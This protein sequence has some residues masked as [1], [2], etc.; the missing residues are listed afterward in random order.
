MISR[1]LPLILSSLAIALSTTLAVSSTATAQDCIMPPTPEPIRVL[2]PDGLPILLRFR[3]TG[4]NHWYEDLDG[5]PVVQVGDGYFFARQDDEGRLLPTNAMVGRGNPTLLG[6]PTG[7]TPPPPPPSSSASGASAALGSKSPTSRG[8]VL[9]FL[10]GTGTVKNLVIL[11]RFSNHGPGGQNRSLPSI[12]DVDKIMNEPGG[13][14]SLA[15]TGSVRDHYLED[16]YGQ[17]TINSTVSVWVD[18]P[19]S[20]SYYANNNSG[21]T[22]RTWDLIT[23]GLN[24]VDAS[25]DFSQFDNDGDGV[26][27]AITFLHSGYGAEWGGTD[28]YGT[29]YTDRM[30]S[31]KWSI[32]TWTS[33][34]GVTVSEYNISPGLWGTSGSGPGRIGVVAH[35]L[36]HFFGLP[37]LYDTD[38]SSNGN[39]NWCLMAAG[40]WGFDGSQQYPSHMGA[41][42]KAKMGWLLPQAILPGNHSVPRVEDTPSVYKVDN[43]YPPGEYLL[44]ENRAAWGFDAQLPT[45][46]LA[47]WH[48]DET[49]GSFGSNNPN[50]DEGYSGQS[51]WPGNGKHYRIALLQADNDYDLERDNNRGDSG[52]LYRGGGVSSITSSS[53]PSSDSYQQ[54]SIIDNGN[55]ITGIGNAG[56][57]IAMTFSNSFSPSITTTSLPNGAQNTAYSHTLTAS[58]GDAPLIWTEHLENPTYGM[59]DLGNNLYSS[60]GTAQGW[61]AD[62][63]IWQLTLP[64]EFPYYDGSY[65]TCYVSSNGFIEFAPTEAEPRNS[66]Y[67]LRASR[68]IAPLWDDLITNGGGSQDIYV[69]TSNNGQVKIRWHGETYSGGNTV[70][71]S[72]VLFNDGRVRFDYGNGNSGISPNVGISRGEGGIYDFPSSHDGAS[73]LSNANS[74]MFTLNGSQMPPGLSLSTGGVLSGTPTADAT[75]TPWFRVTDNKYRYDLAQL[76]IDVGSTTDCNSNGVDDSDDIANGTSQDC[77]INGIPDE[78]EL[79]GND[80]DSNGVPDPCELDC[81]SNSIPD[82]CESGPDCNSN[83]IPDDCDLTGNDCNTNSVPDECELPGNDCNSNGTPDECDLASND[84]NT[85]SIPDECELPGNDCNSNGTPDDC[86]LTGN[87]CNSNGAPDECELVGNDCN[88]NG[89]PDDCELA[90]DCNG[91]TTPDDCELV[92]NDCNSNGFPDECDIIFDCNTNGVPDECEADCNTNGTPD[93]CESGPDCNLNGTPDD[94]ELTGNDCNFNSVPDECDLPANDCNLNGTPDDCELIGN[95][96][97]TNGTPDDCELAGNDCNSNGTPDDCELVGDCNGNSTP[98][99]CELVGNDCN[100]NGFPDECDTLIDCNSNGVPDDCDDDCNSNGIP[101]DCESGPDCNSNGTPDD[102]EL[103]SNDCDLNGVP[104]ECDPDC[105]SN[106]TP[107]ACDSFADCNS[108]SVPDECELPGNDCNTNGIPDECDILFDCNSNGVPDECETDC[109][110]NGNPDD[111][112]SFSDCN[113]NGTPDECDIS[114]GSSQDSDLNGIPDECGP[115]TSYCSGDGSGTP[116]PCANTGAP[117][118]GCANSSS[119]GSTLTASGSSSIL[120]DDLVFHAA[121]LLPGQAALLFS[122][123]NQI[124]GGNG[125]QFGDGLRCVGGQITRLNVRIPDASGDASWGPGMAAV[126]G[127][128]SGE[129]RTFQVWYR[130]SIGSSCGTGFNLSNG[131]SVPLTN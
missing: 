59:S 10:S 6:I 36:G 118:A 43:G 57:N 39:G 4:Y 30:W 80:C 112:E 22:S 37:D 111:C 2:Q 99:E 126:H 103:A 108:N 47:I 16:S 7:V 125:L 61:N 20:E 14:P 113:N 13:H 75:Y 42:A 29:S 91:N 33:A 130:D 50:T 129:T 95:D 17:L 110:N 18:V 76:N 55:A 79:A 87:D 40:S 102:C 28:S 96:C 74:V 41:W 119:V 78:C 86:D 106:N 35:E 93:D 15:P 8:G 71:F 122:G 69:D 24:I 12:A 56:A 68:R 60:S 127:W 81:N 105:N 1:Q 9:P 3:G 83:G 58:G 77:N 73:N 38:G 63:S 67:T 27:D 94:C 52:D 32:P 51:G 65:G 85:N 48:V 44:V 66:P 49:K 131:L 109:N 88:N 104:D 97:N 107:D 84:C 54:G 124:N 89:T 128:I 117:G 120:A 46:G 45:E 82:A 92:G 62:D 25:I 11:L 100:S 64:F 19:D 31:H 53:S 123:F 21:L 23:D 5:H 98:D 116:C 90:G 101:D 26:I 72:V 34:E 70:R 121:G 114:S 115:A